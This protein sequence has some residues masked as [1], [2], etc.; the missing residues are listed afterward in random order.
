MNLNKVTC[1]AL[2]IA[3]FFLQTFV[4]FSQEEEFNIGFKSNP[5]FSISNISK[6]SDFDKHHFKVVNNRISLQIGFAASL[7]NKNWIF[8][9]ESFLTTKKTGLKFYNFTKHIFFY[10]EYY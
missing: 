3:S 2:C 1:N 5:S 8:S 7:L 6:Q 9:Y 4:G 10:S